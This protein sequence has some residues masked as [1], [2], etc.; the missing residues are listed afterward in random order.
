[1]RQH[2][3]EIREIACEAVLQIV[4]TLQYAVGEAHAVDLLSQWEGFRRFCDNALGV[5]PLVLFRALGLENGDPSEELRSA[6]PH[7][8]A[9][10]AEVTRWAAQWARGW[11][12]RFML[13]R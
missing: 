9:N 11:D 12:R 3:T 1:L 2:L 7:A 5:E 13:R 6:Y 4:D 10:D 8:A